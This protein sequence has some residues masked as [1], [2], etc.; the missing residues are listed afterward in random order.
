MNYLAHLHLGGQQPQQLLGSLYG[1]FVKGAALE[2]FS[3]QAQEAIRLH[4]RIDA[5][6]DSHP[7]VRKALERFSVT[8]RR[9]A[10]IALDM[11]FD[12][13]LASNWEQ[14]ADQPLEVFTQ[15]V[16]G[17]LEAEPALPERL[18]QI[19]PLMISED[20]F[21]A[22]R[23]F[24]MI[25][26]G[27]EVISRRLSQPDGLL[28][29]YEELTS[30]YLPLSE[31]FKEFYPLLRQYAQSRLGEAMPKVMVG[32]SSSSSPGYAELL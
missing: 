6:T 30:L 3:I 21:G 25:D 26:H 20:W 19:A 10:G 7:V 2:D 17:L 9:Y 4:R 5:F 1:D 14:Y 27:L 23:D 8:R 18:A 13:C 15:K 24:S 29:A 31:D 11:F 32:G 12:H 16:Y 28:H 22:Y